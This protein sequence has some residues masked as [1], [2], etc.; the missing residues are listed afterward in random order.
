MEIGGHDWKVEGGDL[1][2]L[3]QA[4]KKFWPDCVVEADKPVPGKPGQYMSVDPRD[5]DFEEL[6]F[7]RNAEVQETFA[8]LELFEDLL[9]L[10]VAPCGTWTIVTGQKDLPVVK[11]LQAATG[12]WS[13]WYASNG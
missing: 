2:A 5:L 12:R 3:V 1:L 8:D 9:T 13:S 7:F 6:A 10:H 4:L 11:V